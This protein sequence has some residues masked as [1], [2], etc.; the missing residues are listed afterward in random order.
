MIGFSYIENASSLLSILVKNGRIFSFFVSRKEDLRP[1]TRRG[2][3]YAP[4]SIAR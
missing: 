1:P 2:P 4:A 3:V